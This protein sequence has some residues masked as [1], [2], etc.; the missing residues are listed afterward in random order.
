MAKFK[1]GKLR[2]GTPNKDLSY[3]VSVYNIAFE[4]GDEVVEIPSTF[5][6]EEVTAIGYGEEF[7]KAHEVWCDWHHP[8]KGSDWVDDKYVRSYLTFIVPKFVKKI[9]I[10]KTINDVSYCAFKFDGECAIEIDSE[11][12]NLIV[13]NGKICRR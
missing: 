8:S 6:G 7:E 10:P 12:P 4:E 5:E 9:I 1:I 13:K 3:Y 2:Y 11:N